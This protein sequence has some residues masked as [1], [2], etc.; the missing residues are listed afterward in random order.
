MSGHLEQNHRGNSYI[1]LMR[2]SPDARPLFSRNCVPYFLKSATLIFGSATLIFGSATRIFGNVSLIFGRVTVI[3]TV[4]F[5]R[6]T[7]KNQ[8]VALIARLVTDS[9]ANP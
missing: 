8:H 1:G 6:V 3:V 4:I 2:F 9:D 7:A 5:C